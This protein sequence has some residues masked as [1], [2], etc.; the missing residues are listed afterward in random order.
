MTVQEYLEKNWDKNITIIGIL[1]EEVKL[2]GEL[3]IQDYPNLQEINLPN[4]ELTSLIVINCPKLQIIKVRNNQLT[5]L[6]LGRAKIDAESKPTANEIKELIVGGNELSSLN[7]TN[8]QNIS[9]LMVADNAYLTKLENL[10]WTTLKNINVA[11]TLVNLATDQEELRQENQSLYQAL[12]RWN[13]AGIERKLVLTEA[14]Q[15]PKQAEEAIL[16]LLKKTEQKWREYFEGSEEQQKENSLLH[17]SFAKPELRWKGKQILTWII[18][19]QVDG[20]Y[21]DLVNKWNGGQDYNSAYDF[22]GSLD[23]LMQYLR[24]YNYQQKVEPEKYERQ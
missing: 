20:D 21:Q 18:A 17:L 3:I 14:I 16:R 19:A 12:R 6:E 15:T 7:L 22:D 11:N 1:S 5:R 2:S 4:Q 8:C 23:M 9:K 10:N 24:V 13:E